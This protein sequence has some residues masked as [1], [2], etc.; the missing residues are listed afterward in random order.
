M[1]GQQFQDTL[2]SS[3][4]YRNDMGAEWSELHSQ[5]VAFNSRTLG[6][7]FSQ[8]C[9]DFCSADKSRIPDHLQR[10]L[11]DKMRAS[12]RTGAEFKVSGGIGVCIARMLGINYF[13]ALSRKV[14]LVMKWSSHA[15]ANG[16]CLVHAY[17]KNRDGSRRAQVNN[18]TR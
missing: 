8:P 12:T 11:F 15:R 16:H 14:E 18:E 9:I 3:L 4:T 1:T 17:A 5:I 13:D 10:L 6:R 7:K 2:L